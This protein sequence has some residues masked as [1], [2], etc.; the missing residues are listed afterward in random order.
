MTKTNLSVAIATYNEESNIKDFLDQLRWVP[1]IILVDGQSTDNTVKIA[2]K[3]QNVKL[4][5]TTNKP[6]FHINK[7]LAIDNCSHDWILQLDADERLSDH[8][9]QEILSVIKDNKAFDGYWIKRKNYFLGKF[10]TKGGQYP[11]PVIRLFKK[12]KGKLPC[13]S[14]H[15]QVEITGRVGELKNDLLHYADISF[16]RYLARNNRYTTL[17][18]N[19][20]KKHKTPLNFFSFL[21]YFL[22]L[23]PYWFLLTYLRH[24]GYADGFP[25]FV[26]SWFSSLRFPI[27]YIKFWELTK[28]SRQ[29]D[30]KH[31]WN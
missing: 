17:I 7:Q 4:I 30:L 1:Q 18:A 19:D 29:A 14:V 2:K 27:A 3:Y 16:S 13:L 20:L 28:S 5:S 26:F 8:L 15:E 22:L 10:L 11:D 24:R 9:K 21:K 25:G 6:I 12:G 23:P 31:D